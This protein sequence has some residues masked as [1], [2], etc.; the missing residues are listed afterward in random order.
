MTIGVVEHAPVELANQLVRAARQH[1]RVRLDE[2]LAAE[3]TFV[4]AVD[5]LDRD[6]RLDTAAGPYEIDGL[7]WQ[8]VRRD[9][10]LT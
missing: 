7:A 10:D 8:A 9:G 5:D 6:A 1:D 3:F 2:L 4:G